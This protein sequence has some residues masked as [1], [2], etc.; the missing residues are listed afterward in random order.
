MMTEPRS[1]RPYQ[2]EA[3]I[4]VGAVKGRSNPNPRTGHPGTVRGPTEGRRHE[5]T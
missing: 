1:P 2:T 4:S 3:V 5:A